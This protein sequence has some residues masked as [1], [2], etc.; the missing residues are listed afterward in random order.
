MTELWGPHGWEFMHYIS[1]SY[2]EFPTKE[3]RENYYRFYL[4]IG[5]V[6]PCLK[7]R[8]HYKENMKKHSLLEALDYGKQGLVRWVLD[9]H[10]EVNLKKGKEVWSLEKLMSKYKEITNDYLNSMLEE[11]EEKE[12]IH[13]LLTP[14]PLFNPTLA[15]LL[16][17]G[18]IGYYMY[19]RKND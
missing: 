15:L 4:S 14:Q 11:E 19:S 6:L 12:P 3:D 9:M 1:F 13:D 17:I 18:F 16:G 7:C 10:N 8:A 2:P 5:D